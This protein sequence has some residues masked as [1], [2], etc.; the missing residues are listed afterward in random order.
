MSE[1]RSIFTYGMLQTWRQ[2]PLSLR[3]AMVIVALVAASLVAM[4]ATARPPSVRASADAA[5]V[6]APARDPSVP[7]ADQALHGDGKESDAWIP[8]F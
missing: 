2:L 8:T 1:A 6:V 7:D 3:F 4:A 5:G